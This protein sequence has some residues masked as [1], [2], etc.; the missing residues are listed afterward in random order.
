MMLEEWV[1]ETFNVPDV[2]IEL[3]DD[4]MVIVTLPHTVLEAAVTFNPDG[5]TVSTFTIID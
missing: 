2:E 1:C 3:E 5:E 4:G